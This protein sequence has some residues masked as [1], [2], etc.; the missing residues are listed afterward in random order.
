MARLGELLVAVN[1]ISATQLEQALRAQ[2][3]WGGRLGTNLI[4]LGF[5]DLDELSRQLG[6]QHNLPAAL[7]RHFDRADPQLQAQLGKQ[8]ADKHSLVPLLHLAEGQIALAGMD[9]LDEDAYREIATALGVSPPALVMSIAA[10]QRMRYQLER[11]YGLARGARYLRSRGT[12]I[13]PFPTF[14]DFADEADSEVEIPID[15]PIDDPLDVPIDVPVDVPIDEDGELEIPIEQDTGDDD[16]TIAIPRADTDALSAAIEQAAA[17]AKLE[18]EPQGR[19]RR[20]Y[21]KTIDEG[22][23]PRGQHERKREPSRP[24]KQLGRI[25]IR[26]VA[27]TNNAGMAPVVVPASEEREIDSLGDIAKAIR[28]S[29]D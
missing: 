20:A 28:R 29:P 14:G 5:I 16:P 17:A 13:P 1:L 21:I 10:E 9:P 7:A 2:I 23:S 3:V 4:E 22:A 6:K 27:L 8:L 11:V 19:E 26:K 25:A 24:R 12:S 15:I 18:I